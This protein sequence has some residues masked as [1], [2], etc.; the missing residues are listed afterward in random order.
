MKRQE[1]HFDFEESHE[2]T[3]LETEKRWEKANLAIVLR[4]RNRR[5]GKS[6]AKQRER[7]TAAERK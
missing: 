2:N 5:E 6:E 1:Q 3:K 4:A 7:D